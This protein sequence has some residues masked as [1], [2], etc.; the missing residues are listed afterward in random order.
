[1]AARNFMQQRTI[2]GPAVDLSQSIQRL[3]SEPDDLGNGCRRLHS[4]TQGTAV[5]GDS[6]TVD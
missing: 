1:M 2:Q 5:Q 4:S 3:G 6:A